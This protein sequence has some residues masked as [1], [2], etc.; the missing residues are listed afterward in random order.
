MGDAIAAAHELVSGAGAG[1]AD[2]QR[3]VKEQE[4][5]MMQQ[6]QASSGSNLA[7][8]DETEGNEADDA[9]P[10]EVPKPKKKKAKNRLQ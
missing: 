4:V 10:L 2:Y 1:R 9:S 6:R 7:P 8:N 5:V 3:R